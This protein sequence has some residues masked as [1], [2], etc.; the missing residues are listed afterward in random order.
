MQTPSHQTEAKQ[1]ASNASTMIEA[2][3]RHR[4]GVKAALARWT[5]DEQHATSEERR[6][7]LKLIQALR[8]DLNRME[9]TLD[10]DSN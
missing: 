8:A 9:E 5:G 6:T 4:Q 1:A 3:R 7:L 10:A 2:L